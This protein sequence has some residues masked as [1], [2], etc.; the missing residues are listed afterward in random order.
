VHWYLAELEIAEAEPQAGASSDA[1][2][3][4]AAREYDR[5][6]KQFVESGQT[7]AA[8]DQARQALD[9]PQAENL[10]QAEKAA[11]QRKR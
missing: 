1:A 7:E 2:G 5:D 6:V 4:E 8:A 10:K 3:R 11:K 9:D